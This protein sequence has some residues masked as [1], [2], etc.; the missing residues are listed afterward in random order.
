MIISQ[1]ENKNKQQTKIACGEDW[2]ESF[3]LRN[4]NA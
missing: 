1:K 3:S 2:A 4:S